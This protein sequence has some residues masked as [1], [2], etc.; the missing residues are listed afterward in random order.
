MLSCSLW[1]TDKTDTG[2]L[3]LEPSPDF[4][5]IVR[6]P[7]LHHSP[8]SPKA[9]KCQKMLSQQMP[10]I[11][12]P[13]PSSLFYAFSHCSVSCSSSF[14]KYPRSLPSTASAEAP[15]L[16]H[17]FLD[18]TEPSYA[19]HT[20]WP[21]RDWCFNK[22]LLWKYLWK[23]LSLR[24]QMS[25][26]KIRLIVLPPRA[27]GTRAGWAAGNPFSNELWLIQLKMVELLCHTKTCSLQGCNCEDC[28]KGKKKPL[29]VYTQPLALFFL[30]QL[31]GRLFNLFPHENH[32]D[33][34]TMTSG[35]L[36]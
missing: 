22:L 35:C 2:I 10:W 24:A 4:R 30:S 28:L 8:F 36:G 15:F 19:P 5:D 6:T 32:T 23:G 29:H 16:G 25:F 14:H 11:S 3:S 26:N 7:A 12:L 31:R 20:T 27:A 17:S 9:D 21:G 33:S 13:E 18:I 1:L 34:P